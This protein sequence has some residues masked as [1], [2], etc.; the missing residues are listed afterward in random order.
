MVDLFLLLFL[1]AAVV[2]AVGGVV[3][4]MLVIKRSRGQANAVLAAPAEVLGV[5]EVTAGGRPQHWVGVRFLDG[6]QRELLATA[7][8]ARV[9]YRGQSGIVHY[10]GDRLT[11]WVPELKGGPQDSHHSD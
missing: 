7:S 4:V 5:R 9:I 8:Q 10:A 11:G 2:L 3:A 6:S 1:L